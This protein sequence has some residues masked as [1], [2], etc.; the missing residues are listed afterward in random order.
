MRMS[1]KATKMWRN[2]PVPTGDCF[3]WEADS[4]YI[5]RPPFLEQLTL[6]SAPGVRRSAS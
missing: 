6:Y 3:A 5:R 2:L 4:T 1:L